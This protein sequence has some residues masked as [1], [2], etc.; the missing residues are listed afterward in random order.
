MHLMFLRKALRLLS[1]LI[2]SEESRLS[3]LTIYNIRNCF[4]NNTYSCV[5][6][7]IEIIFFNLHQ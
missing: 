6:V 3:T 1:R 5:F 7:D 2:F 4:M